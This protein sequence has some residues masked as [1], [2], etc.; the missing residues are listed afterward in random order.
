MII[1]WYFKEPKEKYVCMSISLF[2]VDEYIKHNKN[3][4]PY[5][6]L[7]EKIMQKIVIKI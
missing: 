1:T 4:R 6:V 3:D 7:D 5:N 2:V